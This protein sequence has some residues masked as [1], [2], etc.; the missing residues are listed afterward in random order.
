[1]IRSFDSKLAKDLFD[2][3]NLRSGHTYYYRL[4]QVDFDGKF[5]YS[6]IVSITLKGGQDVISEFY[7]NP[8]STGF[9]SV[10]INSK[11]KGEWTTDIFDMSGKVIRTEKRLL[12]GENAVLKFDVT[13]LSQGIYFVKFENELICVDL[14]GSMSPYYVQLFVWLFLQKN[15]DITIYLLW[16]KIMNR[17]TLQDLADRLKVSKSTV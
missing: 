16:W 1:M 17:I 9:A 8:V 2:D 11:T 4:K 13:G 10:E 5:D 12:E 3:K 14:T 15:I 6:K 7:P